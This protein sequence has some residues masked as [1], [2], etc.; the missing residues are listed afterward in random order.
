[1]S[2]MCFQVDAVRNQSNDRIR[3]LTEEVHALEMVSGRLSVQ[4]L[5]GY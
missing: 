3:K 2:A 1:M 4:L 5:M